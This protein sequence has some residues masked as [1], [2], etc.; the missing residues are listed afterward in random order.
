ME[1]LLMT[2][3]KNVKID[4]SEKIPDIMEGIIMRELLKE[5]HKY[6]ITMS[7]DRWTTRVP[8]PT[9][10]KGLRQVKK[11]SRA[12]LYKYLLEFYAI[13][14]T[15]KDITFGELFTEWIEYKRQFVG[16]KNK[17]LSPSTI[18]RYERDYANYL[19]AS[20]LAGNNV[21]K[22][23]AV[24]LQSELKNIIEIN[25]GNKNHRAMYMKCFKNIFGYINEMYEYAIQKQYVTE[26][27]IKYVDKRLLLTFCEPDPIKPDKDRVL[28]TREMS[29]LFTAVMGHE[30]RHCRYMPNYAIELAM[31]TGMRVGEIAALH[32]TD[33]D[34]EYIHVNYS[35]HRL[36]YVDRPCEY[37]IGEPKNRKHR[38]IPITPET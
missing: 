29:A 34:D 23:T 4:L 24:F 31:L 10:P 14:E 36:D 27:P 12:D 35:E 8:D 9:K 33:I 32:W 38:H 6:K 11:K 17:G 16:A 26:A 5:V 28:T 7:G 13:A 25:G 1:K 21:N 18:R 3:S 22:I 20:N 37:V 19:A 15:S 30:R 2:I